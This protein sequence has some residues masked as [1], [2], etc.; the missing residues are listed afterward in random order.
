MAAGR[1]AKARH[2]V[3]EAISQL[4]TCLRL[5]ALRGGDA[6]VTTRKTEREC[7]LMLG[8]LA[9]VVDSRKSLALLVTRIK[10]PSRA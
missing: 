2:A 8:D 4:E 5:V 9:G 3:R 10:S 1:L 6:A 7:L